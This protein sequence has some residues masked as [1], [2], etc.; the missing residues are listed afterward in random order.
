MTQ[1]GP[2]LHKPNPKLGCS[3]PPKTR[4]AF[5]LREDIHNKVWHSYGFWHERI[6]EYIRVMKMTWTNIWIYLKY[7]F[8][9]EYPNKYWDQKYFNNWIFEYIHHTLHLT[10]YIWYLRFVI[11][12]LTFD[13]CHLTFTN[14][15][16]IFENWQLKFY[17]WH[18]TFDNEITWYLLYIQIFFIILAQ[19]LFFTH[20]IW[21]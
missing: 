12:Y 4:V 9:N 6:S 11:W 3:A 20:G 7:F 8:T 15:H 17:Y 19:S 10:F 18:L 21:G 1:E 14:C 13:T 2:C 5:H 16:L